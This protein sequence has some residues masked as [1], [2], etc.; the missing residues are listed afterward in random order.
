MAVVVGV[1]AEAL[2]SP[3]AENT[4]TVKRGLFA[5][6]YLADKCHANQ[7]LLDDQ[8]AI[9]GASWVGAII[10]SY[11]SVHAFLSIIIRMSNLSF[12]RIH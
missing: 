9:A 11:V 3:L 5:I 10:P 12:C 4:E 6:A 2:Q 1:L 7:I 8:G